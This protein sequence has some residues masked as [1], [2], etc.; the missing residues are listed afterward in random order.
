MLFEMRTLT[1]QQFG[2]EEHLVAVASTGVI[3]E[4]LPMETVRGGI[5][6]LSPTEDEQ[7]AF[8]FL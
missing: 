8:G 6:Q 7:D 4:M 3:G 1:A 2:L 5:S